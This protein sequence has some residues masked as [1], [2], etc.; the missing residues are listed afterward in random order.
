MLLISVKKIQNKKK[1]TKNQYTT[2]ELVTKKTK[3]DNFPELRVD[4]SF[5]KFPTITRYTLIS[6]N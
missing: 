4:Q 2:N 3:T 5:K 1:N 6:K